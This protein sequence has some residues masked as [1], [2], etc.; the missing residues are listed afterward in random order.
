MNKENTP[1]VPG[2]GVRNSKG[3]FVRGNPGG[4][5]MAMKPAPRMMTIDTLRADL[6]SNWAT[7]GES[8]VNRFLDNLR[9]QDPQGYAKLMVSLVPKDRDTV[10]RKQVVMAFYPEEPPKDCW[11]ELKDCNTYEAPADDADSN[12]APA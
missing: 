11:P 3:Q 8:G 1:T 2:H 6:L 5:S 10:V 9:K 4:Q 7:M 12:R